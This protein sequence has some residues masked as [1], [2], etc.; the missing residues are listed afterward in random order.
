MDS[1]ELTE[2]IHRRLRL[3]IKTDD[4]REECLII[5]EQWRKFIETASEEKVKEFERRTIG[6]ESFAMIVEGIKYERDKEKYL[7]ELEQR[8]HIG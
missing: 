2:A 4:D 1:R 6:L 8:E 7:A 5:G 3:G